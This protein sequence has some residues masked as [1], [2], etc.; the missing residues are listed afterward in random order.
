[1]TATC[2]VSDNMSRELLQRVFEPL[3]QSKFVVAA[4]CSVGHMSCSFQR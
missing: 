3:N 4:T 2:A 1:M